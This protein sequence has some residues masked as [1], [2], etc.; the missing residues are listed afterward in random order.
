M[1]VNF[2][3]SQLTLHWAAFGSMLVSVWGTWHILP[4]YSLDLIYKRERQVQA[5]IKSDWSHRVCL[6]YFREYS[7]TNSHSILGWHNIVICFHH[8]FIILNSL[9]E[10]KQKLCL[11]LEGPIGNIILGRKFRWWIVPL[12]TSVRPFL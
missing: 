6:D 12:R 11:L 2:H 4:L 9:G 3:G 10:N 8:M 1:W 7:V 5:L